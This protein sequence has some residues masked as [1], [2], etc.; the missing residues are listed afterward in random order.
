MRIFQIV[1]FKSTPGRCH[2]NSSRGF[3]SRVLPCKAPWKAMAERLQRRPRPLWNGRRG[4][5]TCVD[6]KSRSGPAK[7]SDLHASAP[8]RPRPHALPL[9]PSHCSPAWPHVHLGSRRLV[10]VPRH[11]LV[12]RK[13]Q[14]DGVPVNSPVNK[15]MTGHAKEATGEQRYVRN[16]HG[17]AGDRERAEGCPLRRQKQTLYKSRARLGN[18]PRD[19]NT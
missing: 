16:A 8:N 6:S 2:V 1:A 9:A 18:G 12:H 7:G 4:S 14:R 13:I 17:Q 3:R 19:L 15:K 10:S 11:F 5:W